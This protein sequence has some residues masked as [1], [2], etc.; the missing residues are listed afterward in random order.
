VVIITV[1][2]FGLYVWVID[3]IIGKSLDSMLRYLKTR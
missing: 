1:F 2:L 3:S